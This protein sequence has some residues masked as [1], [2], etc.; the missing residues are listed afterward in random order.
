[1]EDPMALRTVALTMAMCALVASCSP[2]D[3]VQ[4]SD[5]WGRPTP[6]AAVNTAFYMTIEDGGGGDTLVAVATDACGMTQ[7]HETTMTDG[8]M[9]MS[10]VDGGIAIPA[11]EGVT[12]E[13]G[14]LHVMCMNVTEPLEV[15]DTVDLELEFAEAGTVA[16]TAEIRE[17]DP[18][19]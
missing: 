1:M 5:A 18:D 14:G 2:T 8:S 9:S 10:E 12:L 17:G 7:L 11:G 4:V 15:G 16:V 3:E 6:D 13:P 19:M